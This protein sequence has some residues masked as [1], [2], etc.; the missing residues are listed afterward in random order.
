M[1]VRKIPKSF[2][3][4]TGRFPSRINGNKCIGYESSLEHD[5]YLT[6]EFDRTIKRYE[7]QP[8]KVPGTYKGKVVNYFPDCLVTYLQDRKMSLLEFKY[9]EEYK[10][11]SDELKAKIARLEEFA[12]ENNMVFEVRT[13]AVLDE[14]VLANYRL[15]YHHLKPPLGIDFK[16]SKI[17]NVLIEK[18]PLTIKEVLNSLADHQTEQANYTRSIWHLLFTGEIEADLSR[19]L[20]NN[21]VIRIPH[22]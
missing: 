7:E 6:F 3:A 20:L 15:L 5:N 16:R 1:P 14:I 8:I 10:T 11:M 4:V 17:L 12:S 18:G 9:E 13:E 2:R 22:G 21:P 19:P